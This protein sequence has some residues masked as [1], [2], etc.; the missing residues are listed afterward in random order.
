MKSEQEIRDLFETADRLL[1]RFCALVESGAIDESW[2]A[3]RYPRSIKAIASTLAWVLDEA[4][5]NPPEG[6]QTT[7]DFVRDF[8]TETA[9]LAQVSLQAK[10]RPGR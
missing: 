8:E 6:F 2:T 3:H 10:G 7:E 4:S 1:E 5:E 9:K